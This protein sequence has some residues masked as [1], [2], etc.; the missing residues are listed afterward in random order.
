MNVKVFIEKSEDGSYSAYMED[1]KALDFTINGQGSTAPMAKNEF[2]ANYKELV[3]MYNEEGKKLPKI[4]FK[5]EYDI[6]S[7][8]NYYDGILS[9]SG[10]EKITGINQKQLWHY[11]S[12]IR[13]PSKQKIMAI[14]E[15]LR[16]FGKE[17]SCIELVD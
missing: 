6:A 17:L 11:S 2:L 4:V 7:L 16:K 5:F 13:K 8:F 3:E 9:K 15:S 1:V 10:L 12:G 14:Q